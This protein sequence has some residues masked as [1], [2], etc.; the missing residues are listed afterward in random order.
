MTSVPANDLSVLFLNAYDHG[1]AATASRRLM[2]AVR[3]LGVDATMLVQ[4]KTSADSAIVGPSGKAKKALAAVRP[5]LDRLPVAAYGE[6]VNGFSPSWLPDNLDKRVEDF[7]PAVVQ[8]NWMTNGF[9]NVKTPGRI[10]RPLVWR[11][12]DMW[13]LTGGCHYNYGCDRFTDSCGSCPKLG[14]QRQFDLSWWTLRRKRQTWNDGDITVVAPSRWLAEQAERSSAL[15]CRRIE[16][17]PNALDTATFE[18]M[19]PQV[20]RALFDLPADD[21]LVLFGAGNPLGDHRKGHDLLRMALVEL[22]TEGGLEDVHLVIFGTDDPEEPPDFGFDTTYVG[23]LEDDVSLA[24]LYSAADAMVVPSRYEGFGQTAAEALACGTPVVAFDATGPRDIVDHEE[25]G[26]LADPYDP[27]DLA[28]G[29][30]WVLVETDDD[31]TLSEQA[32]TVAVERYDYGAVGQQY[33]SLYAD[34]RG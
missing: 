2:E 13:P 28:R 8:L 10:D 1:G 19:D 29:I 21:R 32:R 30:E 3:R 16:V 34:I 9:M 11:L 22:A 7:D 26:Y 17:I 24:M 25:T 14:S 23:Y 31:A 20:G 33:L 15:D 5:V 6:V 12:P 27:S 18:P 4:G